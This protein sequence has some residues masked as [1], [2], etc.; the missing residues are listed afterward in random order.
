[1]YVV[2]F[3]EHVITGTNLIFSDEDMSNF[4]LQLAKKLRSHA[5]K[6]EDE[7]M[8]DDDDNIVYEDIEDK[9]V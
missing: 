2:K 4:R 6:A 7:I 1:M 3:V 8:T 9:D 5:V